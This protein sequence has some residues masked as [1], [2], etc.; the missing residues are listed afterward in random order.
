MSRRDS[1][2]NFVQES[3]SVSAR[4][5]LCQRL[6]DTR[7]PQKLSCCCSAARGRL[8]KKLSAI[9]LSAA[10]QYS[11]RLELHPARYMRFVRIL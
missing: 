6:D 11:A 10:E 3:E 9:C 2:D 7:G 8:R 4:Q 5:A 1:R